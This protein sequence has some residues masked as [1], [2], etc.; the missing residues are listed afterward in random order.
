MDSV[1]VFDRL[2]L[3]RTFE[4]AE[5]AVRDGDEPFGAVI[6]LDG[7]IVEEAQNQVRRTNDPTAH[8]ELLVIR[9]A[10]ALLSEDQRRRTVLYTNK[11]PCPMCAG[12]IYWAWIGR[13]V[14]GCSTHT[15]RRLRGQGMSVSCRVILEGGA[16]HVHVDGPV[17][18]DEAVEL[19][20]DYRLTDRSA[21]HGDIAV[22]VVNT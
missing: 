14:F 16:S 21:R 6:T 20:R 1:A 9:K 17:L 11:E 7:Q 5:Q 13:V 15:F 4:I 2:M 22:D 12:A 10:V 8:A 19:L 3:R 18:E